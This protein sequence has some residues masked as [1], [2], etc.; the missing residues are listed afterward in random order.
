MGNTNVKGTAAPPPVAAADTKITSP[1]NAP[2]SAGSKGTASPTPSNNTT[3]SSSGDNAGAIKD[4]PRPKT[5]VKC[6]EPQ[7]PRNPAIKRFSVPEDKVCWS[8][9]YPGYEPPEYTA[10]NVASKP[11][12]ADKDYK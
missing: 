9:P 3:V 6:I 7:Y 4:A 8:T 10:P 1:K 2:S 5:H 12:W 11:V